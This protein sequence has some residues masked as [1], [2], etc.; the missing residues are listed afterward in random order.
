MTMRL[1]YELRLSSRCWNA[2]RPQSSMSVLC[3][4][5]MSLEGEQKIAQ[6]IKQSGEVNECGVGGWDGQAVVENDAG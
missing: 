5:V 3:S 6:L 2:A 1:A 4:I